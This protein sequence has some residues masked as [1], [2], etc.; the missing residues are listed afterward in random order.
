MIDGTPKNK[1]RKPLDF[2]IQN[3]GGGRYYF[4]RLDGTTLT[5]G[6]YTDKG[7][8]ERIK[9]MKNPYPHNMFP[10]VQIEFDEQA[11]KQEIES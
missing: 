6:V 4:M 8:I 9:S 5:E 2:I 11:E 1:P 10:Y 3:L 7:E